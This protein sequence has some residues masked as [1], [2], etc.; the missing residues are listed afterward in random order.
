MDELVTPK[1]V[2]IVTSG[3]DYN[4]LFGLTAD[5][6]VYKWCDLYDSE[7]KKHYSQWLQCVTERVPRR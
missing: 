2:Q 6:D 7:T 4:R 3:N 5:G 1:F